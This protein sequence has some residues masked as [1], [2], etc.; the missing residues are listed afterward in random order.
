MKIYDRYDDYVAAFSDMSGPQPVYAAEALSDLYIDDA[1]ADGS[2]LC[3]LWK[4][5]VGFEAATVKADGH[6][7]KVLGVAHVTLSQDEGGCLWKALYEESARRWLNMCH[8]RKDKVVVYDS[9][10]DRLPAY[11]SETAPSIPDLHKAVAEWL[12]ANL[13]LDG[14][15]TLY[16]F[17]D[18][19]SDNVLQ[20]VARSVLNT[21]VTALEGS[22]DALEY[23]RDCSRLDLS[24]MEL[25]PGETKRFLLEERTDRAAF[26]Q[27]DVCEI[28]D[29]RKPDI[30]LGS[31]SA[32]ALELTSQADM[33]GNS[34]LSVKFADG[35]E[36]TLVNV[37]KTF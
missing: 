19:S 1:S 24:E 14:S 22:F 8:F 15:V 12:S 37:K 23:E 18:L 29:G 10:Y 20:Y 2:K 4:T 6:L 34:S 25:R 3:F 21:P 31:I 5:T 16:I 9:Y 28:V 26:G 13:R 17:G 35:T 27:F 30:R 36:K 32:Y 11:D 7:R 33:I